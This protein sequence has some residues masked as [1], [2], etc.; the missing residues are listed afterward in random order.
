MPASEADTRKL[1]AGEAECRQAQHALAQLPPAGLDHW[2]AAPPSGAGV[3]LPR[4]L[5]TLLTTVLDTIAR[6]GTVTIGSLP[7]DVTTTTAAEM[8]GVSR[9]TL[10]KMIAKGD[11]PAHK[12]GS[13]TRLR[14]AEVLAFARARLARQRAAFDE[15]VGLEDED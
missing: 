12:V 13:H 8:L 4:E 3:A 5:S 10:M 7:D 11:L 15:L 9:P 14:S 1:V 6:G 2:V